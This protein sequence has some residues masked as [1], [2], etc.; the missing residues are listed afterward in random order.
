MAASGYAV[1]WR[2]HYF[3]ARV[4]RG[5]TVL[6]SLRFRNSGDQIWRDSVKLTY[7]WSSAGQVSPSKDDNNRALLHR[8]VA[9]GEDV[10]LDRIP[11]RTPEAP[12]NYVLKF[13][14]VNELVA[15]FS[16]KGA[17]TLSIP[18]LVN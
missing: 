7:R 8:P 14:L 18:V 6:A 5:T 4:E 3:P 1:E 11:V 2:E 13:D 12:G 17:P 16:D 10:L 9:P 15:F